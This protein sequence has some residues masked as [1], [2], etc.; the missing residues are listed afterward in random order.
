MAEE[1]HV[2]DAVKSLAAARGKGENIP[3]EE[4][5]WSVFSQHDEGKHRATAEV[6][7]G[8]D[9][10]RRA[11]RTREEGVGIIDALASAIRVV[12][13]GAYGFPLDEIRV[14]ECHVTAY[15]NGN[16]RDVFGTEVPA[17]ARIVFSAPFAA[18][19][20]RKCGNTECRHQWT[21][22]AKDDDLAVAAG[23]A[24]R[25]GYAYYIRLMILRARGSSRAQ[26]RPSRNMA[27]AA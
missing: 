7:L 13:E 20:K 9:N 6:A 2:V 3:L 8:P 5:V 11:E 23:K 19:K 12:A 26:R 10:R 4:I 25:D 15:A 16:G 22:S 1:W 24:M 14:E 27:V 21:A 18:G 17:I